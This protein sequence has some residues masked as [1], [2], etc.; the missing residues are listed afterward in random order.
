MKTTTEA[1]IK[2]LKIVLILN[3]YI[4]EEKISSCFETDGSLIT[5]GQQIANAFANNFQSI[6]SQI[7]FLKCVKH[8]FYQF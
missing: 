8:I 5:V 4:N 3:V 6:Y 1:L 7:L 2:L